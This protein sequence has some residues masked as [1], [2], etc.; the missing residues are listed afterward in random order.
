M[1]G[2]EEEVSSEIRELAEQAELRLIPVKSKDAYCKE[3]QKCMMW[4]ES[5]NSKTVNES[6]MLAYMMEMV[7]LIN[8]H[9]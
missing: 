3:Y 1:N 2:F 9:N 4:I 8:N 7:T 5:K 6:V